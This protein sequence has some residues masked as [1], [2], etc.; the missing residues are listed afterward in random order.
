MT[1]DVQSVPRSLQTSLIS[2]IKILSDMDIAERRSPQ[3]RP[4][5][6]VPVCRAFIRSTL[7]AGRR[8]DRLVE[9]RR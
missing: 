8:P 7:A 6:Q 1:I 9:T 5:G 3:S 2:R 4:A